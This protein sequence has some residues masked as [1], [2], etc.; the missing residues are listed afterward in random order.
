MTQNHRL[1]AP[2]WPFVFAAIILLC[3]V[4]VFAAN[5][6]F[7]SKT[8]T[9]PSP[10][11]PQLSSD[12]EFPFVDWNY[13]H[14]VNAD[15]IGWITIPETSIN[16]PIVQ[17]KADNP[18][19]YL[20]TDVYGNWNPYGAIYLDADCMAEGLKSQNSVIYGHNMGNES[21][22]MFAEL[23]SM[24]SRD[25]ATSHQNV[26]IQTP[27]WKQ[28]IKVCFSEV[29]NGADATK[30]T[31]FETQNSYKHWYGE[32]KTHA[33]LVLRESIVDRVYSLVTCSYNYFSNERTIVYAGIPSSTSDN[34]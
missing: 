16:S 18:Q 24:T 32:R 28:H 14:S 2:C 23:A 9:S 5:I 7:E 17:A 6:F 3:V 34:A 12:D 33:A 22:S 8:K 29:V 19:K 1:K 4:L 30:T 25:Y 21:H 11:S 27:E 31:A 10:F 20:W 26:L 13:W 15:I